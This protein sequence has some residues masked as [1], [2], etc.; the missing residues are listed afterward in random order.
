MRMNS[1]KRWGNF[2]VSESNPFALDRAQMRDAFER[3]ARSYD[4]A[5]GLQREVADRLLERLE[6]VR[7][8]PRRILDIGCGT[9]YCSDW[10]ARRYAGAQVV[11]SDIAPAMLRQARRRS[12]WHW[13]ARRRRYLG[14]DAERLPLAPA[15]I[16]LI[17]SNLALQWCQPAAAFAEFRRVLRPGGLLV[18]T[19]FGPDTLTELRAAWRAADNRPHVHSF[20]DLRDVGDLLLASGFADPVVDVERLVLRYP[21]VL[22]VLRDLKRIG[23]HNVARERARGL[24]G[25]RA[26]DEF[27]RAYEAQADAGG[28]PATY[29]VVF[30]HAWAPTVE[31]MRTQ[32]HEHAEAVIPLSSIRRRR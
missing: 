30:G 17:V 22:D 18:F 14:G 31:Q 26:F 16:D 19:T 5:A 3:A 25:R 7:L 10:L 13:S 27:R 24:T 8:A 32:G 2:Y 6:V 21:A 4:A 1:W 29:E 28:I 20:L 15:S 9:G 12:W 11:A 23:A